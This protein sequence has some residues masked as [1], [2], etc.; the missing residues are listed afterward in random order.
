MNLKELK[1]LKNDKSLFQSYFYRDELMR[2]WSYYGESI[3]ET[4]TVNEVSKVLI[5][6]VNWSQR[7]NDYELLDSM[8]NLYRPGD[9]CFIE[10]GLPYADE[11]GYQRLCL[12]VSKTN[13]KLLIVPMANNKTYYDEAIKYHSPGYMPFPE[14]EQIGGRYISPKTTL[15]L[16]DLNFVSPIRVIRPIGHIDEKAELFLEIKKRIK[17]MI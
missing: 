7:K 10:L 1:A 13:E 11:D 4:M 17:E 14:N 6:L 2:D 15:L 3:F 5:S 8:K 9:I 16:N 12:I